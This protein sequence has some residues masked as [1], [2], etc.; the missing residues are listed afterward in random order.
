MP[1]KV[2]SIKRNYL[3]V[4]IP[5]NG[6]FGYI[7]LQTSKSEEELQ[8]IY[9]KGTTLKAIIIGFP[10]DEKAYRDQGP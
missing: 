9:E 6:L 4:I 8:K 5:E 10:F 1:V 2:L 7:K 3:N